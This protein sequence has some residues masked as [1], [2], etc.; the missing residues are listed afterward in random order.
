MYKNFLLNKSALL[1]SLPYLNKPL[2]KKITMSLLL[3]VGGS[4]AYAVNTSALDTLTTVNN[5][6]TLKSRLFATEQ[7]V[8]TGKVTDENNGPLPGVAVR[9]KKSSVTAV[10][11]NAGNY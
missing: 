5:N 4:Q 1:L 7:I 9:I 11:D 3:T 6:V 2:L 10:T 8:V